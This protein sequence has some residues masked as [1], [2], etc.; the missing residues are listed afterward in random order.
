MFKELMVLGFLA[1]SMDANAI[2]LNETKQKLINKFEMKAKT[3]KI[4]KDL[5]AITNISFG[6]TNIK[7]RPKKLII[8]NKVDDEIFNL[9][10]N[11]KDIKMKFSVSF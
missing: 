3:F 9:E 5:D 1:L 10:T 11:G 7:V 8:E 6:N 4:V 2:D